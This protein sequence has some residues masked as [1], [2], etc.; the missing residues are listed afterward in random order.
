MK[1]ILVDAV[2]GIVI[3]ENGAFKLYRE[4][5]DLL[6]TF[7]ER[8][9]IVTNAAKDGAFQKYG[10]EDMPYEVFTLEHNPEKT[11]P[12]YWETLLTQYGLMA[13]EVVYFEHNPDAVESAESV[14]IKSY[15]Y[16]PEERDLEALG[17][18]L[19]EALA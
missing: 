9:I 19:K 14:G 1:T 10:L 15:Y 8:K 18:F 11:D 17:E 7:S 12:K 3:E 6:E 5:Y 13:D 4:M 2:D 16:D